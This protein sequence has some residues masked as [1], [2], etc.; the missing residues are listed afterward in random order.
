MRPE[1][2]QHLGQRFLKCGARGEPMPARR[3]RPQPGP[4]H[5]LL[6]RVA[7]S[8]R[9]VRVGHSGRLPRRAG[10]FQNRRPRGVGE[11]RILIEEFIRDIAVTY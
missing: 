9:G 11:R 2:G 4:D 1:G 7:H 5:T 6:R 10:A 8:R 3:V